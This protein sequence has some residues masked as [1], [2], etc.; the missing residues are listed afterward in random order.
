MLPGDLP[1]TPA[2][3]SIICQRICFLSQEEKQ[4]SQ[5]SACGQA[6]NLSDVGPGGRWT[7]GQRLLK[8]VTHAS[9]TSVSALR[10]G[11]PG[12][13]QS[14]PRV[15]SPRS[16]HS[17][18]APRPLHPARA[19]CRP[20]RRM[21]CLS[22]PSD[23]RKNIPFETPQMFPQP[24]CRCPTPREPGV[25]CA[26]EDPLRSLTRPPVS[27][28]RALQI[29]VPSRNHRDGLPWWCSG[30]ESAW[31]CRGHGFEPWSGK[32]PHAAEQLSPR[33]TTT[34]PAL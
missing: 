34:E 23:H 27:T 3:C 2:L 4:D 25:L 1:L 11:E 18:T 5:Q 10:F 32:I 12:R 24:R 6:C 33:A 16:S 14:H 20:G 31:Q 26:P 15:L 8:R 22:G 19:P 13:S 28:S 7:E 21:R 17:P 9:H 30:W 29:C